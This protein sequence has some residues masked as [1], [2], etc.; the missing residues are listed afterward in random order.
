MSTNNIV[1]GFQFTFKNYETR[2]PNH[3]FRSK[4][5]KYSD[6]MDELIEYVSRFEYGGELEIKK[7]IIFKITDDERS[8]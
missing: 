8:N 4:S 3:M 5:N 7:I 6:A 1:I 2:L